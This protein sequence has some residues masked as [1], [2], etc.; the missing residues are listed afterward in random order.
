MKSQ[1]PLSNYMI[2]G[3]ITMV[4]GSAH[5]ACPIF[6]KWIIGVK[7]IHALQAWLHGIRQPILLVLRRKNLYAI[8]SEKQHERHSTWGDEYFDNIYDAQQGRIAF[9]I[10]NTLKPK[11]RPLYGVP[12][13]RIAWRR[14][15]SEE[16]VKDLGSISMVSDDV[17]FD[18][19]YIKSSHRKEFD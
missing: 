3:K 1:A 15:S 12:R 6:T 13:K 4:G 7:R 19:L 2:P 14:R 11:T 8:N 9:P 10:K 18:L 17:A 5:K 16:G